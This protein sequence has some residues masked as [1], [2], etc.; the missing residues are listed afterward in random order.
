MKYHPVICD[1]PAG[2]SNS[3]YNAFNSSPGPLRL[4]AGTL[5]GIPILLT[6]PPG[7]CE[8]SHAQSGASIP[9]APSGEFPLNKTIPAGL[10]PDQ[11]VPLLIA[12]WQRAGASQCRSLQFCNSSIGELSTSSFPSSL[13]CLSGE[14]LT[15][16]KMIADCGFYGEAEE[17]ARAPGTGRPGREFV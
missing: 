13:C 14:I 11:A 17:Q 3:G 1:F 4:S 15:P 10:Q 2:R 9:A 5:G 8:P 6:I 12:A 7:L 16:V